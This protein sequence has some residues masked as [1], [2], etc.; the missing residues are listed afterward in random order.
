MAKST[1]NM[2]DD[3]MSR[4]DTLAEEMLRLRRNQSET[5]VALSRLQN[6]LGTLQRHVQALP[7]SLGDPQRAPQ[8]ST[9]LHRYEPTQGAILVPE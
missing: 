2:N 9:D 5:S 3:V 7:G 8:Y 4:L 6:D 1:E